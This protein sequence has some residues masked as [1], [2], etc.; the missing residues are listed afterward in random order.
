MASPGAST[1]YLFLLTRRCSGIEQRQNRISEAEME[2]PGT[3][4]LLRVL[5]PEQVHHAA[6]EMLARI[7]DWGNFVREALQAP[8]DDFVETVLAEYVPNVEPKVFLVHE[9]PQ[10]QIV[11]NHFDVPT[12]N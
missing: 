12:F 8:E 1:V 4:E 9:E 11:L 2:L 7:G 5:P 3:F 6:G 10:F